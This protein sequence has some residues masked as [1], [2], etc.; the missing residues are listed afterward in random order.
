MDV[1]IALG[2]I[3]LGLGLGSFANVVIH[4]VPAGESVV[5]PPSAC[6]A[7][8]S[9]VKARHNIP[10]FGWLWLRGKCADCSAIISARYPIVEALMGVGFLLVALAVGPSWELPLYLAFV[11]F[12]V[13]LSAIDFETQRLPDKVVAAFAIITFVCLLAATAASGEWGSL[14]RAVVSAVALGAFYLGAF[15][16]YPRGMGFGDVKMAPVLGAVLGFAGWAALTVGTFAAFLW[17]ALVGVIVMAE[18]RRSRGVRIPFGPW[19]FAGAWT[20]ITAGSGVASW[21]L[22]VAGLT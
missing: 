12:T 11:F 4:R 9:A 2:A 8:G 7:C 19:M 20:G 10:V 1:I 15:L 14:V 16:V 6:P 22:N 13:V 18:R 3:L 21:Y 5:T 17:G